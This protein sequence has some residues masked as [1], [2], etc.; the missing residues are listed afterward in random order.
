MSKKARAVAG[1]PTPRW[2]ESQK[3]WRIDCMYQGQRERLSI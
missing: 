2:I 3:H 1:M